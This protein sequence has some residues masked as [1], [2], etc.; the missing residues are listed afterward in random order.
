MAYT[1]LVLKFLALYTV[2]FM[3]AEISPLFISTTIHYFVL[4]FITLALAAINMIRTSEIS[5]ALASSYNQV[6]F[7]ENSR[8]F[9]LVCLSK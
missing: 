1:K 9:D 4:C 5:E 8:L 2:L 7:V 3:V 6:F